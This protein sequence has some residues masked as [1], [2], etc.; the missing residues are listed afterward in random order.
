M[1]NSV[2]SR[3]DG[4]GAGADTFGSGKSDIKGPGGGRN[5]PL[6]APSASSAAAVME[7]ITCSKGS[8]PPTEGTV[9]AAIPFKTLSKDTMDG[10][11]DP[12]IL[13]AVDAMGGPKGIC[14]VAKDGVSLLDGTGESAGGVGKAGF[15][16]AEL[17][18]S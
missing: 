4:V 2:V 16:I 18:V 5:P 7:D 11:P 8:A 3:G 17:N 13:V 15:G 12:G 9:C 6:A 1:L 14:G 10:K